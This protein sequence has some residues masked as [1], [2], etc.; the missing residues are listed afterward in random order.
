MKASRNIMRS[1]TTDFLG[2]TIQDGLHD[3]ID[4]SGK[5]IGYICEMSALGI[6]SVNYLLSCF[7]TFTR[8]THR[9]GCKYP[10]EQ[11]C[12]D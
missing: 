9:G 12:P 7:L 4:K 8:E 1:F 3:I 6:E 10:G 11:Q 2:L 5:Y